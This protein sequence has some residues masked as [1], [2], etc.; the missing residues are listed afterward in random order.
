MSQEGNPTRPPEPLSEQQEKS[1]VQQL[2]AELA[3]TRR[4]LQATVEELESSNEELMSAN[5]ALQSTAEELDTSNEALQSVK[6]E[7]SFANDGLRRRND[8]LARARDEIARLTGIQERRAKELQAMLTMVPVGVK[9]CDDIE[10]GRVRLNAKGAEILGVPEDAD[11]SWR[12]EPAL[13]TM[14]RD[15]R[16]LA[17]EERPFQRVLRDGRPV[18]AEQLSIR[19]ADASVRDIEQS[20]WPVFDEAGKVTGVVSMFNDVTDRKREFETWKAQQSA[21]ADLGLFALNENDVDAVLQRVLASLC[22][23]LDSARCEVWR[24]DAQRNALSLA[25][26]SDDA[27]GD[28]EDV[29][30]DS[31]NLFGYTLGSEQAVVVEHAA[32]ETRFTYPPH[33][34]AQGMIRSLS[35]PVKA[36]GALWGVLA[37]HDHLQRQFLPHDMNFLQSVADLL[38]GVLRRKQLEIGHGQDQ[39]RQALAEAE[40]RM[41]QAERLASLGTLA[42]GIA[43]EVNNPLNAILMNAELGLVSLQSEGGHE[44]L[45]GLLDTIIKEAQ[46]GGSITRNVLQFSKA[47]H[48]SPKG[49]A[50]LNNLIARARDHVAPVLH[51]HN[52]TLEL[53]LEPTLPRLEL[54]QIAMEQA[55]VNLISNAAQSGA[56]RVRVMTKRDARHVCV[57]ISDDGRG[58]PQG[59][60]E[61]IFDPFYTTRRSQGGSGLG[62]SLV[63]RIVADHDGTVEAHSAAGEGT[64]FI[65][66]LPL[67]DA[68]A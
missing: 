34:Q 67:A 57:T 59:E 49:L 38:G 2:E 18:H 21:L 41:R 9:V 25:A 54:N 64:Q 30:A 42:A 68:D 55:L 26:T 58:I 6:G 20:A 17:D 23:V 39:R 51:K 28:P 31:D 1:L 32:T 62:L 3:R 46:R 12:S 8:R 43:H 61:H 29:S 50:D 56:S 44:K 10:R 5:E 16:P 24:L 7:L 48:F 4:H 35:V 52:V 33:L 40:F 36:N 60:I 66:R 65:L 45:P 63:H 19:R 14:F 22:A 47:D 53:S 27:A 13:F 15:G 37:V 11:I